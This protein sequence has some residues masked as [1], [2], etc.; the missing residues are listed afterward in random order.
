MLNTFAITLRT[1]VLDDFSFTV[2]G[3][4]NAL[5]LHHAKDALLLLDDHS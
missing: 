2:T 1:L 4:T 3:R 5:C